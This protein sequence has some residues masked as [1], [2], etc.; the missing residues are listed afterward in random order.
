MC[1][2]EAAVE[3]E[4]IRMKYAFAM[5]LSW[6]VIEAD[7]RIMSEEVDYFDEWFPPELLQTLELDN[8]DERL[9]MYKRAVE[10]LPNRLSLEERL[11]IV[12]ML[13]GAS[14]SDGY[15]EFRQFGVLEAASAALEIPQETFLSYFERIFEAAQ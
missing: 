4:L 14:V 3:R 8:P 13:I 6:Q 10:E 2:W 12:G 7:Q 5:Q 1:G 15:M 11:E 9:T